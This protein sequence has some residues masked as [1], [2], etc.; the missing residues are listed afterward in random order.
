[1]FFNLFSNLFAE[2]LTAGYKR[3]FDVPSSEKALLK[4]P[5]FIQS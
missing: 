4:Y 3:Q 1:M 5:H 2:L